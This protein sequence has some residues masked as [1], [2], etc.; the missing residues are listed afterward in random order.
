M[1]TFPKANLPN[2]FL[3]LLFLSS[4][5]VGYTLKFSTQELSVKFKAEES[6][7]AR[8]Q[9][10]QIT[11]NA[12]KFLGVQ[13]VQETLKVGVES[14]LSPKSAATKPTNLLTRRPHQLSYVGSFFQCSRGCKYYWSEATGWRIFNS[15]QGEWEEITY[16]S[17]T[18]V[19]THNIY[20]NNIG[21]FSTQPVAHGY[22]FDPQ[23]GWVYF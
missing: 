6:A 21:N 11:K 2:L 13:I 15:Q 12:L 20:I 9:W 18:V 7:Y 22:G 1:K 14:V 5:S 3:P 19:R 16:P 8:P 10:G 4:F 17:R 23:Y